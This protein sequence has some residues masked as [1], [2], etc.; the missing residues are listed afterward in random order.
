[1]ATM[2]EYMRSFAKKRAETNVYLFFVLVVLVLIILVFVFVAFAFAAFAFIAV[3]QLIA[4][5][6][7][8]I[9]ILLAVLLAVLLDVRRCLF[10]ALH[11]PLCQLL[12]HLEELLT[13]IL[14]QIICN[15]ENIAGT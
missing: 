7:T 6:I 4:I 3:A 13:I 2:N 15:G 12:H 10:F 5:A 9:A 11:S 8:H 1:M 14:E